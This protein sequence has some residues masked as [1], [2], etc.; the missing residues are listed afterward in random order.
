M[1]PVRPWSPTR[2]DLRYN[3]STFLDMGVVR[4][5]STPGS[6][7]CGA[8][9][10]PREDRETAW[11]VEALLHS[12]AEPSLPLQAIAKHAAL[13]PF[14][15]GAVAGNHLRINPRLHLLRYGMNADLVEI[16]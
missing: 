3:L 11:L 13:F 7:V 16:Q 6:Y 2:M 14:E 10:R 5:G 4:I 1:W 12:R 15:L 9:H 8:V